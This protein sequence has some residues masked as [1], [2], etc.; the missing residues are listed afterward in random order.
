MTWTLLTS[1]PS[2]SLL[3]ERLRRLKEQYEREGMRLSVHAV[4]VVLEHNIPHVLL[5]RVGV[6]DSVTAPV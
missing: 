4:L 2:N 6:V 3:Q 5:L 1:I